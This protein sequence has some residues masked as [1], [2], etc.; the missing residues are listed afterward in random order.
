LLDNI[1]QL[2]RNGNFVAIRNIQSKSIIQQNGLL[3]VET[4]AI[5]RADFQSRWTAL[6]FRDSDGSGMS[7]KGAVQP[8][9]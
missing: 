6:K 1:R 2:G 4:N 9:L 5:L 7:V 3:Q 8:Y